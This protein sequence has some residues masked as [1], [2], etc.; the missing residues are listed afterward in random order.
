MPQN[1]NPGNQTFEVTNK[2]RS[3]IFTTLGRVK[4]PN[5]KRGKTLWKQGYRTLRWEGKDANEDELTYTL[6]FRPENTDRWL[7]MAEDLKINFYSFDTTVLPDGFY[8]FRVG[9]DDAKA[10]RAGEELEAHEVSELVAVDNTTPTLARRSREG[11][12]LKV[13]VEDG[14]SPLREAEISVDAEAW[15][16][17][18][19]RRRDTRRN[20][21]DLHGRRTGRRRS[22]APSGRGFGA[23]RDDLR[24]VERR[25]LT[26]DRA[27]KRIAVYPGSFDP[28]HN[29]HLDLVHRCR[30]IFD[31]VIVAVLRNEEKKPVFSAAERVEMINEQIGD[32]PDCRAESFSG[33]LVHYLEQIGATTIVRGL[34]AVSDFE[35]E[36]QMALMNRRLK[37][38]FETVFMMPKGR[39]IYLSSRLVQ[40]GAHVWWHLEG[41]VP[42]EVLHRLS[43]KIVP[44]RGTDGLEDEG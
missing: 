30:S 10:N 39:Y 37:P 19:P 17:A 14:L 32:Y 36:F 33:L 42:D 22:L 6:S 27:K 11:G 29:G 28:V 38:E 8:R 23:Q 34:R 35:Y 21:G 4:L 13:T 7:P 3:G 15:S 16:E 41:L 31:E 2:S 43:E 26:T 44:R 18:I 25:R 20:D 12:R 5:E 40:G 1:F 9:V 24:S